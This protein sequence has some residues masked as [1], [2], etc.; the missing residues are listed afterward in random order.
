MLVLPILV[1]MIWVYFDAKAFKEKGVAISPM[2]ETILVVL[3]WIICFPLYLLNRPGY[4]FK[5]AEIAKK[6]TSDR[7]RC[8][9]C[10]EH[11][12]LKARMC[13]F[14][15]AVITEKDK[16]KQMVRNFARNKHALVR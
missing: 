12:P 8:P 5:A 15:R 14:C 16:P 9:E 3:F 7:F 6:K 13:R 11:I 4:K 10:G 2:N 1:S